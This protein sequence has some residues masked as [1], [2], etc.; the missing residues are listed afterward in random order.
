MIDTDES[1]DLINSHFDQYVNG[2]FATAYLVIQTVRGVLERFGVNLPDIHPT[3]FDEEIV[4]R[5]TDLSGDDED[6]YLC[7][8]IDVDGNG[9]YD[10]YAQFVDGD[11]LDEVLDMDI[12]TDEL[13]PQQL[14]SPYLRQTR[15]T[16]DD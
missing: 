9:H 7:I 5:A 14:V 4:L 8:M 11:E 6:L 1:I 3:G 10:A 16:A 15:R 2:K 13:S 12:E